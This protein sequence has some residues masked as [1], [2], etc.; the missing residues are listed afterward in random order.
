MAYEKIILKKENSDDKLYPRTLTSQLVD[1]NENT[2]TPQAQLTTGTGI[3]IN[4]NIIQTNLTI[5]GTRPTSNNWE[6]DTV[7]RVLDEEPTEN[8]NNLLSSGSIYLYTLQR[9]STTT[10]FVFDSGNLDTYGTKVNTAIANAYLSFVNNMGSSDEQA[11]ADVRIIVLTKTHS[12]PPI[13]ITI[14]N[15]HLQTP[16]EDGENRLNK[17]IT[18]T[19]RYSGKLIGEIIEDT[20][21]D[22]FQ[23]AAIYNTPETGIYDEWTELTI[24]VCY[25][26]YRG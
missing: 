26:G 11:V 1:D 20:V 18:F 25:D 16:N 6:M 4:N 21:A 19:V 22:F 2:F 23:T 15:G 12:N 17:D 3:S 13:R 5:N 7:T 10:P 8:S 14:P 24:I 9:I